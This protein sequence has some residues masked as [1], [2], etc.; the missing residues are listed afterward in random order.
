MF[1]FDGWLVDPEASTLNKEQHVRVE[2]RAMAVLVLMLQNSGRVLSVSQIL[3]SVWGDAD[4]GDNALHRIIAQLRKALGDNSRSPRYISSVPRRGYRFLA[5]VETVAL[6]SRGSGVVDIEVSIEIGVDSIRA[7]ELERLFVRYFGWR[8][9]A[10][11]VLE[12]FQ[13][14][15]AGGYRL[16]VGVT[17]GNSDIVWSWSV[18]EAGTGER[19]TAD[20]TRSPGS[21]DSGHASAIA[22]SIAEACAGEILRVSLLRLRSKASKRSWSYWDRLLFADRYRSMENEQIEVRREAILEAIALEPG[23]PY[24]FAAYAEFL[25]W[26]IANGLSD[27][28]RSTVATVIELCDTAL[29]IDPNEIYSLLRCGSALSRIRQYDRGLELT[30]RGAELFPSMIALEYHALALSFGG[31]PEQAKE[32]YE[33]I[34]QMIPAG[35]SFHYGRVVVPYYQLAQYDEA[36]TYVV[37]AVKHYP[38]DYFVWLLLANQQ[39]LS[40]ELGVARSSL[41]HAIKLF[42]ALD[43]SAAIQGFRS[44]YG[45]YPEHGDNFVAGL[46]RLMSDR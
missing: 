40:G 1:R 21:T 22:E 10:F 19:I 29:E 35:R 18:V 31:R 9:A 39:A 16:N 23:L 4:V 11:R 2:P 14:R 43:L 20:V 15:T 26:E 25:S 41:T 38:K 45:R 6:P 42:P 34:L 46:E 7:A 36:E 32:V 37:L 30:S 12:P 17:E 28:V 3:D 27:D 33:R 24:A 5:E 13:R 8:S 44:L